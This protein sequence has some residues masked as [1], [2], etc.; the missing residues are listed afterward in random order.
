MTRGLMVGFVAE[1]GGAEVPENLFE[2]AGVQPL[3]KT[4]S[5]AAALHRACP[6]LR[7]IFGLGASRLKRVVFS[8][9]ISALSS[10]S[11]GSSVILA[12]AH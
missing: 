3:S 12:Q 2:T 7:D 10:E 8:I 1:R 6:M 4:A 11:N 5:R 9:W